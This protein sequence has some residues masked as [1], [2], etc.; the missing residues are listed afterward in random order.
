MD[1]LWRVTWDKKTAR[2]YGVVVQGDSHK[3][4]RI[5]LVNTSDGINYQYVDKLKIDEAPNESTVQ[6]TENGTMRLIVRCEE[7]DKKGRVGYSEFPYREWKWYDLGFRLGG[8]NIVTLP[9]GK[10][11]IGSRYHPTTANFP[12][13]TML[14]LLKENQELEKCLQL[15]GEGDTSYTGFLIN[16]DELWVSYYSTHEG[17]TSVYLAKVKLSFFD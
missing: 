9:N 15:P 2:G 12:A 3:G 6:F 13:H 14:F 1:W 17:K 8:P 10:V 4:S 5:L 11:I 7:G 16:N